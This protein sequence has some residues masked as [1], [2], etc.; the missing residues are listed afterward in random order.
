MDVEKRKK[1]EAAGWA[2]G[3]TLQFLDLTPEE[4]EL[5][6]LRLTLSRQIKS[7]REEQKLTQQALAN[8]IKSSQSRVA[9][10][11]AGDPSV[12]LDLLFRAAFALGATRETLFRNTAQNL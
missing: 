5:I 7:L 12:S 9:K 11:E 6:E 10:V 1:L 8:R 3:D 2:I 4:S